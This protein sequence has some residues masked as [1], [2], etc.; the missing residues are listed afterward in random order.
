MGRL[1]HAHVWSC[2]IVTIQDVSWIFG[3]TSWHHP[4]CSWWGSLILGKSRLMIFSLLYNN[5]RVPLEVVW[6]KVS[7]VFAFKV[8]RFFLWWSSTCREYVK[9]LVCRFFLVI[10]ISK[11]TKSTIDWS[12]WVLTS[13]LL[14]YTSVDGLLGLWP[15]YQSLREHGHT[16]RVIYFVSSG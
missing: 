5:L 15:V 1:F 3:W 8:K 11:P 14:G 13:D 4:A 9:L 6:V 10:S 12:D 2:L 16:L 7:V